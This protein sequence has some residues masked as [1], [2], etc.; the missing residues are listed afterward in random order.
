MRLWAG[1]LRAV[2]R[3]WAH[4][5]DDEERGRVRMLRRASARTSAEARFSVARVVLSQELGVAP[6]AVRLARPGV[7]SVT[8]PTVVR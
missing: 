8:A 3:R 6:S 1:S 5:L 4:Y 2:P 7:A